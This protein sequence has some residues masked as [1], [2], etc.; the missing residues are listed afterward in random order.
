MPFD[1]SRWNRPAN[2]GDVAG[3][4][5]YAATGLLAMR[6]ALQSIRK[7]DD[8]DRHLKKIDEVYEA[9]NKVFEEMSGYQP[10]DGSDNAK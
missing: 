9:L 4:A 1:T 8:P 2:Q 6:A 10:S 3:I 5:L 7:G